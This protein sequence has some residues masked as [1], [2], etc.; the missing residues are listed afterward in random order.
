MDS[1][2]D[3]DYRQVFMLAPVGQCISRW[4]VIVQANARLE[5]IFRY[6]PGQLNGTSFDAL[7]PNSREGSR[8]GQRT[9]PPSL[10]ANG[11]YACERIMQR[12]DGELFWCRLIGRSLTPAEPHAIGIWT[13]EDLSSRIPAP[14]DLAERE[15]AIALMIA[16]GKTSKMIAGELNLSPRTVEMYRSRLLA[17]LAAGTSADL[18]GLL[19]GPG[20]R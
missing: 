13:F 8:T 16:Q 14:P 11:V 4:R 10:S 18:A 3:V 6:P 5:S 12:L 20:A 19:T 2:P 17:K 15:R 1:Q 7:Y 9:P